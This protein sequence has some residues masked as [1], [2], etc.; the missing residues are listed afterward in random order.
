[1]TRTESA[2]ITTRAQVTDGLSV[3][4]TI[5]DATVH[6][7]CESS[8]E[9]G[10]GDDEP[11]RWA[12]RHTDLTDHS[13]LEDALGSVLADPPE[14]WLALLEV[15]SPEGTWPQQVW[16]VIHELATDIHAAID[17]RVAAIAEGQ[18]PG[19]AVAAAGTG[20]RSPS[21]VLRIDTVGSARDLEAAL[22]TLT[23]AGHA[24]EDAEEAA[25]RAAACGELLAA[26]V[27][28]AELLAGC[29]YRTPARPD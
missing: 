26:A 15:G 18:D 20:H 27:D 19:L 17:R 10:V 3:R 29:E 8:R 5:Q 11:A 12:I 25:A 23:A 13:S 2:S 4:V 6:L 9:T 7:V 28:A 1:M 24:V 14:E 21:G 22:V 16:R